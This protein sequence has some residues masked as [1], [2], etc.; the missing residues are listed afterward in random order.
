MK[1]TVYYRRTELWVGKFGIFWG[2]IWGVE[3]PNGNFYGW[4]TL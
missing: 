2:G 4:S 3:F 1:K